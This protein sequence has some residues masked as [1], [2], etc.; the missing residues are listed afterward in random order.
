MPNAI[1]C[2]MDSKKVIVGLSNG[3]GFAKKISAHSK[4]KLEKYSFRNFPDGEVYVKF[5]SDLNGKEVVL[6]QS[7]SLR[8]NDFL[9]ELIFAARTAKAMGAKKVTAVTPYLAYMRQ[10]KVF[11]F[12]ESFSAKEMASLLC[13]AVDELFTFE[14]HLHRLQ[15]LS[16]IFSIKATSLSASE[17][18]A[19][20][21]S[22]KF[23][24]KDTIIVGPDLESSKWAKKIADMIGFESS[25]FEKT[26]FSDRHVKVRVAKEV[27]WK[28][29]N[30]VIIDDIISTGKTVVESVKELKKRKQRAIYCICVHAL[31]VEGALEKILNAG[32]KK[33]ISCNTVP[34]KTNRIDLSDELVKFF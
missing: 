5:D 14:P 17:K 9:I 32:A 1:I 10:D 25:I 15:S 23:S 7:L 6:V 3:I 4:I 33:V 26:R 31:L 8:P 16:A 11:N 28:N 22:K 21:V 27:E 18:I 19:N 12:G 2:P 20:F 34:S 29:K 30:V 24:S 13:V